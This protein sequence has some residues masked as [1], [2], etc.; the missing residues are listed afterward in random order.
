MKNRITAR[1]IAIG[2]VILAIMILS[3]FFKN[4]SV[5]ITGPIVNVCLIIATLASGLLIGVI[6]SIIAP[7]TSF[8]ITGAPI[9]AAIPLIMPAIMVGNII[10]CVC[11]HMFNR[12]MKNRLGLPVGLIAGSV[13]KALFMG[14]VISNCLLVYITT[15]LP[16]AAINMA[17]T[18][19]SGTQLTTSLIGS[20]VAYVIWLIAGKY[21]KSQAREK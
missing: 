6:L 5:Y 16:E 14:V 4:M 10:L 17:K 18:T 12:Y 19:F 1:E 11:V 2:G 20:A 3:Q 15:G 7:I 8:L 21:L 13:L 9:I